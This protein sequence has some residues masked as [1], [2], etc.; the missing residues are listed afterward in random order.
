MPE[1]AWDAELV[2]FPRPVVLSRDRH[3]RPLRV[4]FVLAEILDYNRRAIATGRGSPA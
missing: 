4:A 3:G 2:D 1:A